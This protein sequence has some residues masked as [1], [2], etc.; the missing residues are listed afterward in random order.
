M[1]QAISTRKKSGQRVGIVTMLINLSLFVVKFLAGLLANSIAVLADSFNN[2]ADCT[3]SI[4]TFLGFRLSARRADKEHPYGH[5]RM[6]Y[7]SG[8]IVSMV[9]MMTAVGVAEAAIRRIV[10]PEP[11]EPAVLPIVV[12]VAAI[13]AKLLMALYVHWSN[14]KIQSKTLVASVRDSISDVFATLIALLSL[15]LA[16]LTD[17]PL[18]GWLG[19]A[20]TAFIVWSGVRSFW[21]NLTL[22]LGQGLDKNTARQIRAEL[23]EF[24]IVARVDGLDLHDY[25]PEE[26]ILLVKIDLAKSP[27]SVE[28]EKTMEEIKQTMREKFN[29]DETIIYWPPIVHR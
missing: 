29:I 15:I 4:A 28:F 23:H 6:E 24:D 3:S 17:F 10:Q 2:L 8:V 9:I 27:H 26:R 21:D 12:C 16:P 7:I 14:K 19:L 13:V 11:I 18:D 1:T 20:V 22:I 25:G 5:G